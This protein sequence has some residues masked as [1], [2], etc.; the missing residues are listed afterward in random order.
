MICS[1]L[2]ID[3]LLDSSL[4]HNLIQE[5]NQPLSPGTTNSRITEG[6][7]TNPSNNSHRDEN[8]RVRVKRTP[9]DIYRVPNEASALLGDGK[10]PRAL[11]LA[12]EEGADS[13]SP[14]VA[15][16]IY[17]NLAANVVLLAGKLVGQIERP[18]SRSRKADLLPVRSSSC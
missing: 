9:K 2:Y 11:E 14:I 1:Y 16:A 13:G 10:G 4:P 5:Y 12:E 8:G 15:V 7:S 18:V 3:R 17:I 6:S